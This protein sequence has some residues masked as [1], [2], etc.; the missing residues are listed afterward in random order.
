MLLLPSLKFFVIFSP[1]GL[2]SNFGSF[3]ITEEEA[4]W[5]RNFVDEPS[6]T[7]LHWVSSTV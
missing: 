1:F 5:L 3:V 4:G 7:D 6:F 2:W